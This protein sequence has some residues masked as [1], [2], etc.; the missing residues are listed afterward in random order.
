MTAD[1]ASKQPN[2]LYYGDNLDILREYIAA[3]SVDLVYLDPPFNS[4]RNYSVLFKDKSGEES[5]AQIEAFED[6]WQWGDEAEDTFHE[7]AGESSYEVSKAITAMRELIGSNQIMAYL[8]MMT[9]RLA[10]LHRV[11]KPTGTLYLHCDTTAS[12][13]LKIMMDAIFGPTSYMNEV[14]WKRSSAHSDSKQGMRRFGKIR[15][16]ILVYTKSKV[17]TGERTWNTLYTPY[18]EEYAANEY[19]H[20]A[21]DGRRYS[22]GNPTA[23]KP[24]GDVEYDWRVKK[25]VEPGSRWEAD[26]ENEYESAKPGHEYKAVRPYN[27]RYWAYS[28]ANMVEL[29]KSGH[30]IHRSTGMPRLV[31]YAD[32]MPGVP[33]QDLWDDIAP[34]SGGESLGYPTQ[35]PVRLLERIIETSSDPGD[36]VLDPFAGCGTTVDAAQRLGRRWIG[37]DVTH[38]SIALLRTRLETTFP[39]LEVNVVG[40]PKDVSAAQ[41]LAEED[42]FQF[43]WWALSLLPA[44]PLGTKGGKT[45]KRGADGGVD[46]VMTFFE[47]LQKGAKPKRV[48]VQVKGGRNVGV[49]D[50]KN[51]RTTVDDEKAAIGVYVSLVK[52][53]RPMEQSA[54]EA[55]RY[56]SSVWGTFPKIQILTI[57]ELLQG[58]RVDMPPQA[59]NQ[60][61]ARRYSPDGT[62]ALDI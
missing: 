13:Y 35:K 7:L 31:Q 29:A 11:L 2:T 3:E 9:A 50:I 24:G 18:T 62:M 19:R 55:G 15:D 53:T 28:K 42:K 61:Q 52:P 40:E 22:E 54:R 20:I 44:R 43:Q 23:A 51:L 8:V 45:G 37:I 46:G 4:N 26:I 14:A 36:L 33:L 12:H 1:G 47:S 59:V 57:E 21:P 41:A 58:R 60:K 27:N 32:E 5:Q 56:E 25:S 39:E 38:L 34:A 6:T 10:E 49:G 16:V 48:V 30:L 17:Q